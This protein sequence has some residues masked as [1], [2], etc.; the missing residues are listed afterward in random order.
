MVTSVHVYMC[1][2]N[3]DWLELDMDE[4]KGLL[5]YCAEY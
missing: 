5:L 3:W 1:Y 2:I 4:V